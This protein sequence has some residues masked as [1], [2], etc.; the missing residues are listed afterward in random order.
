MCI[1]EPFDVLARELGA[2]ADHVTMILPW[3][4]LFRSV[5]APEHEALQQ[6]AALCLPGATVEIVFSYHD[7]RDAQFALRSS[8]PALTEEHVFQVLPLAYQ[9]AGLSIT[10]VEGIS[11]QALAGYETTWARR[12][13]F[14]RPRRVWRIKATRTA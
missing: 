7:Q 4:N 1:T 12:L 11:H 3:G 9:G 13:A 5:V 14:G 6:I 8:I 10:A 2:V